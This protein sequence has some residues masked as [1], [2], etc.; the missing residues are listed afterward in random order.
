[1][2]MSSKAEKAV[3]RRRGII[4]GAGVPQNN[5][6][7]YRYAAQQQAINGQLNGMNVHNMLRDLAIPGDGKNHKKAQ[8]ARQAR[9]RYNISGARFSQFMADPSQAQRLNNPSQAAAMTQPQRTGPN[10]QAQFYAF[11]RAMAANFGSL[12]G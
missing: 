6:P 7:V 10:S 1:M 2:K 4:S 11:M 8:A 12:R 9:Y 5:V 3:A